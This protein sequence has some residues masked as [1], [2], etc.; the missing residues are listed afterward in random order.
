MKHG[1]LEN[2]PAFLDWI[3]KLVTERYRP[4][5]AGILQEVLHAVI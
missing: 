5:A 2:I 4:P 1:G 3:C